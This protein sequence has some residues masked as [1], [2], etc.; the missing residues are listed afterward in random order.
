MPWSS[1]MKDQR[2][3]VS[4]PKSLDVASW[5]PSWFSNLSII[6][7]PPVSEWWLPGLFLIETF[8][9]MPLDLVLAGYCY[10]K[11]DWAY[12]ISIIC[13]ACSVVSS[14]GSYMIGFFAWE[15]IGHRFVSFFMNQELFAK[16][17]VLYQKYQF[18]VVFFGSLLPIPIKSIT[19]SAGFCKLSL[20]PFMTAIFMSK[21]IR[22]LFVAY[23]SKN[24]GQK[25]LETVKQLTYGRILPLWIIVFRL[26]KSWIS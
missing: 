4:L 19:M 6:S 10:K 2:T 23:I 14:V 12:N 9:I 7:V 26:T 21:L 18:P 17:I 20:V 11:K 13:A 16:I 5:A 25:A 8:I 15:Q 24:F 3:E 22:F 1:A